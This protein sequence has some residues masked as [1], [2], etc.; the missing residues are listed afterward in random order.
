MP[1][2]NLNARRRQNK[3]KDFIDEILNLDSGSLDEALKLEKFLA[4]D[5]ILI[6][7][8]PEELSMAEVRDRQK[9]DNHNMIER[10]RRFNINDRI[11]ELG[12][13]LPKT[14]E[15]LFDIIQ[16][17]HIRQPNKGTILKSS[18][19]YIK[20]LKHEVNRLKRNEQKQKDLDNVNR[21]L[22]TRIR[23]L[24]ALARKHGLSIKE[25]DLNDVESSA[26]VLCEE[27]EAEIIE[28]NDEEVD[29][30][31]E[32]EENE[33]KR[34]QQNSIEQQREFTTTT[35][36]LEIIDADDA[37]KVI[38]LTE[39]ES[40]IDCDTDLK[41]ND[42]LL[43]S[44]PLFDTPPSSSHSNSIPSSP[45]SIS[46]VS[47][48]SKRRRTTLSSSSKHQYKQSTS[49]LSSDDEDVI[50][51]DFDEKSRHKHKKNK[52][53]SS[54]SSTSA[55]ASNNSGSCNISERS[56]ALSLKDPMMMSASHS[57]A[58]FTS[59]LSSYMDQMFF[60]S[61]QYLSPSLAADDTIDLCTIL[62]TENPLG[63][64]N[65]MIMIG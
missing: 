26:Q 19:D 14:N 63:Y 31:D 38:N 48:S 37:K 15:F 7:Q 18:V 29:E 17:L 22:I 10:R 16:D 46:T 21:R 33:V 44:F 60:S 6:K 12:T 50:D 40:L 56:S 1:V 51:D 55:N 13:L 34:N 53:Y 30:D 24:E 35:T 4:D 57:P 59:D 49:F 62:K 47:S 5:S 23:E 42:P 11:K 2:Y 39:L 58:H 45:S 9:K 43:S 54:N 20:C 8:E 65:D 27:E 36:K 64:D 41:L 61:S 25:F 32:E 3:S 52:Y 28:N